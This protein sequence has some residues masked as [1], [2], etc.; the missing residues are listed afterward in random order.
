VKWLFGSRQTLCC[1]RVIV[2]IEQRGDKYVLRGT[3]GN[4]FVGDGIRCSVAERFCLLSR[5][6]IRMY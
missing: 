2:F 6:G 5:E 4:G 3:E 1:N